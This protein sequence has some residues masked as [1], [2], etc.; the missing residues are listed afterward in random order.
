MRN[1]GVSY[2][3]TIIRLCSRWFWL[4]SNRKHRAITLFTL[5]KQGPYHFTLKPTVREIRLQLY[6]PQASELGQHHFLHQKL[7]RTHSRIT[8]ALTLQ[9]IS[10][11]YVT[12]TSSQSHETE[13]L[14]LK[15]N[16]RQGRSQ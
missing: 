5:L 6:F 12:N 15:G 3:Y 13:H 11:T 4:S 16:K 14:V 2:Q 7:N 8:R 1:S 9:S 10:Y